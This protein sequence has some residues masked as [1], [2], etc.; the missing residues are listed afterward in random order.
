MRKVEDLLVLLK[1]D[2][3]GPDEDSYGEQSWE[4]FHWVPFHLF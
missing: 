2:G 3:C 4:S 1:Q